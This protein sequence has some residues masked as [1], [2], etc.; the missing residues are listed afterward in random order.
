MWGDIRYG[1]VID[2][3]AFPYADGPPTPKLILC[4]GLKAGQDAVVALTTSRAP[5]PPITP[6][7]HHKR[8]YFHCQ[9]NKRDCWH[10]NTYV[11]VT[12]IGLLTPKHIADEEWKKHARVIGHLSDHSINA[13]RNCVRDCEDV[14]GKIKALLG[15]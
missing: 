1:A 14:S 3:R 15:T 11:L 6:G 9:Q 10:V 4:V 13:V 12:R 8:G 7:C 5:D 2:H